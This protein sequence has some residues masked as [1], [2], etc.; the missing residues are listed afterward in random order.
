ME[1]GGGTAVAGFEVELIV[2]SGILGLCTVLFISSVQHLA[3]L[4]VS[5]DFI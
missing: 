4:K 2:L 3:L 5:K 1:A